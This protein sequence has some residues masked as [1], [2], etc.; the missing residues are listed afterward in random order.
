MCTLNMTLQLEWRWVLTVAVLAG[1]VVFPTLSV[2][3]L[4]FQMMLHV[5]HKPTHDSQQVQIFKC[6]TKDKSHKYLNL[7]VK[8]AGAL[9]KITPPK[10]SILSIFFSHL[11]FKLF[12]LLQFIIPKALQSHIFLFFDIML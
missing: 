7:H 5:V 10:P 2:L 4:K 12:A 1:G 9:L 3:L 6:I 11:L 8:N